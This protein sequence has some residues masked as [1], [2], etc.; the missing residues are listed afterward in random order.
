MMISIK[1]TGKHFKTQFSVHYWHVKN[2]DECVLNI[3]IRRAFQ[4][5]DKIHVE[6]LIEL[7][8]YEE[9]FYETQF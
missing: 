7:G 1:I 8:Y 2:T 6:Y 5:N 3:S 4:E 9:T